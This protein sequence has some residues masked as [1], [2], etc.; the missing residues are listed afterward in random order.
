M[1]TRVS[2]LCLSQGITQSKIAGYPQK[3][4]TVVLNLEFWRSHAQSY[5]LWPTLKCLGHRAGNHVVPHAILCAST[6]LCRT[7]TGSF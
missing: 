1:S 3:G 4:A 2:G 6:S 5:G 7:L